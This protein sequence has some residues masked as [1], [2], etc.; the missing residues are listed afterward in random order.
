MIKT[1]I[2]LLLLA[3]AA[4]STIGLAETLRAEVS[5]ETKTHTIEVD[6]TRTVR[7]F[8]VNPTG[9]CVSFLND[10]DNTTKPPLAPVI[11]SMNMGSLRFPEGA[12]AENYLFHDLSKGLPGNG[13]LQPRAIVN[14][15]M[16]GH[17]RW[18]TPDGS[19]TPDTLD[20]D[21]YIKLCRESGTEPVVTVSA[22]GHK[23]RAGAIDEEGLLRNAEEWVRYA[24]VTKKW[25]VKYWELGNEVDH[26]ESQEIIT[27]DQYMDIYKKMATRMKAVDPSI[28]TGLGTGHG[29]EYA[30]AALKE[31]PEL[32]DFVV[33]HKYAA[34]I[35]TYDQYLNSR[36]PFFGGVNTTLKTIDSVA[37]EAR[38]QQ[39]EIL[40]TEFSSFSWVKD[41]PLPP[42]RKK[43]SIMNAMITF[44]MLAEGASLDDRV[45]YL[46][47]W[48]THN[49]WK[50]DDSVDYW[51]AL[52]P[53]N[54]IL[55]Q[56]RAVEIMGR[57]VLDRMVEVNC[58]GGPVRCWASAAN[59]GSGAAVWVVNRTQQPQSIQLKINGFTSN[60]P[61]KRW[62]LAGTEPHDVNPTWG[63]GPSE[64][65]RDGQLSLTLAPLSI[66]VLHSK[67][68]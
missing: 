48:V 10:A 18:V 32:V 56:G 7:T 24:N 23:F 58:P 31:F 61:W 66:T 59:D 55:P 37:P 22:K 51:N 36:K 44:E 53:K 25:G 3:L 21:Q 62:A 4:L 50:S 43:N 15:K 63:S 49:P 54:E 46:H 19:L 60:T 47:F 33:V 34:E 16:A 20:F 26:R 41:P 65:L 42:E 14:N 17:G 67:K 12:L 30:R 28:H 9:L 64:S 8:S 68:E 2:A 39:T 6:C 1:N 27:R 29:P 52:G 13:Q 11:K 35:A 5:S 57:F 45:R 38:R 40:I